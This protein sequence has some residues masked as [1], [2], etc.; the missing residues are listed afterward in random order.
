VKSDPEQVTADSF[1]LHSRAVA[2]FWWRPVQYGLAAFWAHLLGVK[3]DS[4]LDSF[5]IVSNV[6]IVGSLFLLAS[7]W[8]VLNFKLAKPDC[9][10]HKI[11]TIG[12]PRERN[13]GME[14]ASNGGARS[15]RVALKS[16]AEEKMKRVT[17]LLA[18]GMFL[19]AATILPTMQAVAQEDH[20]VTDANLGEKLKN[21]KTAADH[22]MIA[23]YYDKQAADNAQK[24]ALHRTMKNVYFKPPL[25]AH[26]SRLAEAYQ[27]AA[28]QDKALAAAQR[29]MAK[30]AGGAARQ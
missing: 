14:L 22:E 23:E 9:Q 16:D 4:H 24:A 17:M 26:C 11:P 28:D 2:E 1:R 12:F 3:S 10:S 13:V 29:A 18:A 6:L 27:E 5:H 19:L 20:V 7:A 8:R 30:Q 21:A 15:R 25:Q